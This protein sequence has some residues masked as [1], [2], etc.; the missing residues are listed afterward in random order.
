M[1]SM[2]RKVFRRSSVVVLLF[3]IT[4]AKDG[5]RP[6]LHLWN[7]NQTAKPDP[8]EKNPPPDLRH[9]MVSAS[10]Q[11]PLSFEP[12]AGQADSEVKF[13]S[14][15]YGSVV[16]LAPKGVVFVPKS[17]LRAKTQQGTGG[18]Q[19]SSLRMNFIE[20]R[21]QVEIRGEKSLPGKSNY[22][23]GADPA[24]WR[25]G[26]PHFANVRYHS[27]YPGVDVVYYGHGQALEFDFVVSPGGDP[28][29][30]QFGL[31]GVRCLE[32][33]NQG[34]L[35]M[36]PQGSQVKY[37]NGSLGTC[38]QSTQIGDQAVVR[39][40][41]PDVY[42]EIGGTRQKI[43]GRYVLLAK[44]R[45]GF[46]LGAFD[47]TRALCIDPVLEYSSYLGGSDDDYAEGIA[48]DAQGNMYLTGT[49]R[50][51]NFPTSLPLKAAVGGLSDAFVSKLNPAGDTLIYSTYLGGTNNDDAKAIAVD[52]VGDAYIAGTTL[53]TDFPTASALQPSFG[54]GF[55]DAFVTKLNSDGSALIYS[56]YLGGSGADLALGLVVD[57]AHNA[58]LTGSTDSANFPTANA[59]QSALGGV[60]DAFVTKVNPSGSILVFSTYL[61]G[62]SADVGLGIAVDGQGNAYVTGRTSSSDFPSTTGVFQHAYSGTGALGDA[63]V[64]K[65]ADT[66]SSF[67]F[68]TFLGGS[69]QDTGAAI[70]LDPHGNV[71]VTGSTGSRDFPVTPGAFK[72]TCSANCDTVDTDAFV[73]KLN[74]SGSALIYSTYL[75]GTYADSG[76]AISVDSLGIAYVAG[77]TKSSDFPA[78]NAIQGTCSGS[79]GT[80]FECNADAFLVKFTPS[81][82]NLIFSTYL[83]GGMDD[84]A[85]GLVAVPPNIAYIAGQTQSGN[86]PTVHPFQANFAGGIFGDAFVSKMSGLALPFETI[87]PMN[88]NFSGQIV[89]TTSPSQV[90][91]LDNSGDGPL[92]ISNVA[93]MG[94]FSETNTCGASV[95][96][97]ASCTFNVT[98]APATAGNRAGSL[99]I[100]DNAAGSPHSVNLSGAATDFSLVA[101]SNGSTSAS[102]TAGSSAT[103]NL[104]VSPLNGFA[105]AV[106]LACTGAPSMS[107]C[108]VS[109]TSVTPGTSAASF[110]VTV[111]TQAPSLVVPHISTRRAPPAAF[112]PLALAFALVLLLFFH[113]SSIPIRPGRRA[114]V[115]CLTVLLFAGL[116]LSACG[117][118]GYT[119]PSNP[120]TPKGTYTL[121]VTGTSNSVSHTL[122]LTLNVN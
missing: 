118:G 116:C 44:N 41:K 59:A 48:V 91:T 88:L 40:H 35:A 62:S 105:S 8:V 39:L 114:L 97:A 111:A 17:S 73:T 95:A 31:E 4:T 32:I 55:Q 68:S 25:T 120:G 80:L 54:G 85:F 89:G 57:S 65:V 78:V 52:E 36:H 29:R 121:T 108:T 11:L 112:F 26:V 69:G 103:Y 14:H 20:P 83:G 58:Y 2:L 99:T 34:N 75:G 27:L 63:F 72:S 98:F 84:M 49:T 102:V 90:V 19:H 104:Q 50:S 7:S 106:S 53:S 61:G 46:E 79:S 87:T 60:Q 74:P 64:T 18:A 6:A 24:R 30:I 51:T 115:S 109:P 43:T 1:N 117:G 23:I 9:S 92:T 16:F 66:G 119:P 100:A 82:S 122:T 76:A 15:L 96:P 71:Y 22:F 21:G 12:N 113:A 33:D 77:M 86:F 67:V 81:G 13:L 101:A 3:C 10:P 93:I 47:R 94:D 45:V 28:S 110:T 70:T 107:M 38:N 37:K 56:T 5:L 42:Q